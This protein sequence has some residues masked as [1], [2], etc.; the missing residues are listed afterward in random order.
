MSIEVRNLSFQYGNR[1]VLN[2]LS[3]SADE[4]DLLCVIGPNGV[5]KS[6]LFKCILGLLKG[7]S[8]EILLSGNNIHKIS[9]KLMA[10][11]IAYIPQ[12]TFPTFNF[13]VLNTVLMGTTSQLGVV[14][15]PKIEQEILAI[16]TLEKLGISYLA[17]RG[18]AEISGGERQLVLIA[19]AMVQQAK[20]LIMDEPTANLDYGN[21]V[22]V[23][24]HVKNL[25]KEGYTII[26]STHNPEHVL[27]YGSKVMVI[28]NGEIISLGEPKLKL[29]QEL[30]EKVYRVKVNLHDIN[31]KNGSVRICI[32][33]NV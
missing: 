26:L 11:E 22:R 14:S 18:Y 31:S 30:L 24:E 8:G 10:R 21:Q 7:Y 6:T 20:V 25:S 4:G 1:K 9:R 28:Y 2:N 13:T 12:S 3:F 17:D 15:S 19:R 33:D 16:E 32:P 5:G 29:S 23:M 27:F